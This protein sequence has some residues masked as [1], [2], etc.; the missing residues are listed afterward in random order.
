M[1]DEDTSEERTVVQ[2]SFAEPYL[3][4]IRDDHSLLV[5]QADKTGDLD[6]VEIQGL[7]TSADW[8]SGCLYEDRMKI[9]CSSESGT[10]NIVG[11]NV[12]LFLLDGNG[13]LSVSHNLP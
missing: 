8:V 10:E 13:N 11:N 12:L 9:F 6:E 5:L 3:L 1:W 4:A 2:A 7:A